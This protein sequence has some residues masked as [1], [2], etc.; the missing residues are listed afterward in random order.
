[1]TE[2]ASSV[3][4]AVIIGGIVRECETRDEAEQLARAWRVPVLIR[5]TYV[6]GWQS[7]TKQAGAVA[8]STC[9]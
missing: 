8:Q 5:H 2:I 4:Y 9:G 7:L 3:E 6:T 1:M